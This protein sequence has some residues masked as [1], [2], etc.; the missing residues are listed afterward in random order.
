LSLRSAWRIRLRL[1]GSS[2]RPMDIWGFEVTGSG[3]Y[4]PGGILQAAEKPRVSSA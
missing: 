2:F 4:G 3:N 1:T